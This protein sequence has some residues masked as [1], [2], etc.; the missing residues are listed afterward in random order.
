MKTG[1][2]ITGGITLGLVGFLLWAFA[3]PTTWEARATGT[4]RAAEGEVRGILSD[5]SAWSQWTAWP[6][7][8]EAVS[9]PPTG[10]GATRTWD[11]SYYGKG[12]FTIIDSRQGFVSYRVV[13]EGGSMTIDG[14]I[15]LDA[16][17]EDTA[18]EWIERGVFSRNP[19]LLFAGR[20]ITEQQS[21]LLA[22]TMSA[23]AE[24]LLG[25]GVGVTPG[26][27]ISGS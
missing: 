16:G 20:R 12:T 25:A 23:L 19:M 1:L 13:V 3:L 2:L 6:D 15:V 10:A 7:G 4:I 8:G 26:D 9:G 24:A 18:I 22:E 5:P 27:S 14:Q 11:D 21:D 17:A